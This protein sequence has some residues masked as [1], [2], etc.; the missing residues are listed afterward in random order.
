MIVK[1]FFN[2]VEGKFNDVYRDSYK[3]V[4]EVGL[5]DFTSDRK[6]P[7]LLVPRSCFPTLGLMINVVNKIC[8]ILF[9]TMLHL[10][11]TSS[12]AV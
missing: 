12:R 10:E 6:H 8:E 1:V 11:E 3:N 9:I 2:D 7:V 5:C 4:H